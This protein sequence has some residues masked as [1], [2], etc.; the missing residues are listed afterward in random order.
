MVVRV[1]KVLRGTSVWHFPKVPWVSVIVTPTLPMSMTNTIPHGQ[2]HPVA[3]VSRVVTIRITTRPPSSLS[4]VS[5]VPRVG[6]VIG[7]VPSTTHS[8]ER[9]AFF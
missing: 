8:R 7:G 2:N 6:S 9:Q 4:P 1:Q 5:T 3:I